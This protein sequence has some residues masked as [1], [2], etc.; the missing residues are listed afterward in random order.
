M[1]IS[2][3]TKRNWQ[4][5]NISWIWRLQSRANKTKSNSR[6]IPRE[7]F[8]DEFLFNLIQWYIFSWY[9]ITEI[10]YSV[11]FGLT[12]NIK[13]DNVVDEL[14]NWNIS[15]DKI[16]EE[17]AS[18]NYIY[19]WD[20]LWWIYQF[21]KTEWEKNSQGSY[22][23]PEF[24][25]NSQIN[26]FFI[27]WQKILDPCCW[28]WQYLLHVDTAFPENIY[29]CDNDELA[30]KI[31]RINLLIKYK[32]LNFKPNIF[33][34]DFIEKNIFDDI[35]FDCIITNP[36]WWAQK[37]KY[38]NFS[39]K[40]GEI[41]SYFIEKWLKLLKIWWVLSY[42][43]PESILNV[44]I[45]SD[46]RWIIL[47]KDI[48]SI[49]E[50]GRVFSGVFTNV[51][52]LDLLNKEED[53]DI[54]IF[55]INGDKS[56]MKKNIFLKNDNFIFSIHETKDDEKCFNKILDKEHFFLSNENCDWALWIVTWDNKKFISEN[57]WIWKIPVYTGKEVDFYKLKNNRKFLL[58]EPEKFQ[59]MASLEKYQAK[60]K[61]IY[62]FI[63]KKLVFALDNEWVFTLNSA[64]IIIPKIDYSL[65]VIIA[66]FNSKL[67]Q[68]FFEKKFNSIKVLKSH[69]QSLPIII[70][71]D[72]VVNKIERM[73]DEVVLGRMEKE[74]LD[75]YIFNL[76]T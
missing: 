28:T 58:F 54:D 59:Q 22:Y 40:S 73:F 64:N 68:N 31:A 43:L 32:E 75:N 52:R 11:A 7:Y 69:I 55:L 47:K 18:Y 2:T 76:L 66:L 8:Y 65:K 48:K 44:W 12:K 4:K 26:D 61:I 45:H 36:P 23:T 56:F 67:Y 10:L 38:T 71:N 53:G 9:S 21:L 62:K 42:V 34:F 5:N 70:F 33:C 1:G 25:A 35:K 41:F 60:N 63:S 16:I 13:S 57:K 17:V 20:I 6:I 50:L 15:D 51:I 72:E 3:A 29:G 49:Y 37:K 14:K 30:V 46:I 39:I 24:I 19:Q 74:V 27:E